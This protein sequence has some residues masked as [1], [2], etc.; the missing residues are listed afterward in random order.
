MLYRPGM[1]GEDAADPTHAEI[2]VRKNR[3]GPLG[4]ALC[5]F[6]AARNSWRDRDGF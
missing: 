6:H 3:L 5:E 1:N 4:T 2:I